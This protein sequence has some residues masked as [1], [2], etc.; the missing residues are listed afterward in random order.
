MKQRA[1]QANTSEDGA[2]RKAATRGSQC[3]EV[4]NKTTM[5]SWPR[6]NANP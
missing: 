4:L 1:D 2:I 5:K 3:G 6:R